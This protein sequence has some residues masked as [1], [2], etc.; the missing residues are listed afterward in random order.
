MARKNL[1]KFLAITLSL[2]VMTACALLSP[3]TSSAAK[4]PE[5]LG[6]GRPNCTTCHGDD[7]LKGALKSYTSF[8]HTPDFVKDHR[9]QATQD[10]A[11]CASCHSQPFCGD[12]HGGKVSMKP[13]TKLGDRP[14]RE[15]Q[16][17]GDYLTLHRMEGKMDPSSCYKCHG[18]ANNDTCRTC[19]R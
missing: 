11:T 19:H 16:H 15:L 8:N 2:G 3:E 13:A 14:D 6:A 18:R 1:L 12:C 9:F 5:E 17:R 10:S 4:H 7:T